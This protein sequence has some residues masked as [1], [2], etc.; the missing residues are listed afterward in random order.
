[1]TSDTPIPRSTVARRVLV[2]FGVTLVAFAVTLGW[3]I[4]AQR[5]AADDS[6][7]LTR[8]YVPTA[9]RVAQLRAAQVC[10]ADLFGGFEIL[11]VV[12]VGVEAVALEAA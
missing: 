2:S 3:G 9:M 11:L 1:M 12:V 4:V 10:L 8:G 5:R 7:E 6:V